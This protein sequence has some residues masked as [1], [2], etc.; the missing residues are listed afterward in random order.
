MYFID[1]KRIFFLDF[2]SFANRKNRRELK[3]KRNDISSSDGI[4]VDN[5]SECD[6]LQEEKSKFY[7]NQ[8]EFQRYQ[9]VHDESELHD[10]VNWELF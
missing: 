10:K 4:P 7:A 5:N 3:N 8:F 9:R 6:I 1:T 2:F